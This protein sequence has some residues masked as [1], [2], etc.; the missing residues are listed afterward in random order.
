[1]EIVEG[2]LR[3][4]ERIWVFILGVVVR[5]LSRKFILFCCRLYEVRVEV[6]RLMRMLLN[7]VGGEV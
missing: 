5:G 2:R 7:N 4:I 6:G 3:I 1:M